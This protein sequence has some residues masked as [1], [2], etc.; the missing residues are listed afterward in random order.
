MD[1]LAPFGNYVIDCI[2]GGAAVSGRLRR[3]SIAKLHL[4][5]AQPHYAF[6]VMPDHGITLGLYLVGKSVKAGNLSGFSCYVSSRL[7][8]APTVTALKEGM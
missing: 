5:K 8:W 7:N 3:L 1:C 2:R 6:P 4:L